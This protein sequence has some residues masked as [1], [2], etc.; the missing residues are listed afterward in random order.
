MILLFRREIADT[1]ACKCAQ[2]AVTRKCFV[3]AA[4]FQQQ[5]HLQ[6]MLLA[7]R[8]FVL[9]ALLDH[10]VHCAVSE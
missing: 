4:M 7:V 3:S 8:L 5:Q 2:A 9:R 6:L 10:C 1:L